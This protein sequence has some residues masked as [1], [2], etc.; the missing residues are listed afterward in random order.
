MTYPHEAHRVKGKLE[1]E[2]IEVHIMDELTVQT[3]NFYSNAIGG[4]KL[5]VRVQDHAAACQLLLE[6]GYIKEPENK[7]NRF[8][9]W[10][11]KLTSGFPVIGK[12]IFEL[13]LVIFSALFLL[14][15]IA[16]V[17]LLS[18]P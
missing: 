14:I 11:D 6:S 4:V 17:L 8:L 9:I 3:N 10:F 13:R 2:N 16:A 5:Q 7:P 1:S 18:A 12:T 15:I